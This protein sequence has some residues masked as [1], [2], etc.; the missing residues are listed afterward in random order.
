M[1]RIYKG[2]VE[3]IE[4]AIEELQKIFKDTGVLLVFFG[5][6]LIYPVLYG[7]IYRNE[8]Y[9]ELPIAVVNQSPSA[10]SRDLIRKM[11]GTPELNVKYRVPEL[12][13]AERLYAQGKVFGVVFVPKSFSAEIKAGV[14]THIQGYC[15]MASMMYYRSFYSGFNYACME[16]N[17]N[18]KISNQLAAGMTQR[19]AETL[20]EPVLS[21]GHALY[22]PTAGFASFLIPAVLVLLLQQ[23]L[24]L[25]V[26]MMAG[27]AREENPE[28][29]LIPKSQKYHKVQRVIWGKAM[30]YLLLYTFLSVYD[31]VLMPYL[32]NLPHLLSFQSV[33]AFLVPY[34]LASVFFSMACSVFFWNRETPLLLYLCTSVPLLFISGLS[35]PGTHIHP[36]WKSLSYLFPSTFGINSFV[37]INTMGSSMTQAAPSLFALWVQSGVYFLFTFFSYKYLIWRSERKALGKLVAADLHGG[38]NVSVEVV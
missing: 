38:E 16:V 23:T 27:T 34:L 10:S 29:H 3:S 35:W 22:N 4:I 36:F 17:K 1:N 26:G 14:Q 9:R 15:N 19:Q 2:F 7:F 21:Q 24:V 30:A 37:Q 31:L 32:F 28:H 13:E 25:G 6:C 33:V 20:S 11:D 5:A 18:I 12:Q 8:T